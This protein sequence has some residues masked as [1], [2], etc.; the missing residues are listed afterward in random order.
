MSSGVERELIHE[1]PE[2]N[3]YEE[4]VEKLDLAPGNKK[5]GEKSYRWYAETLHGRREVELFQKADQ[6]S[7]LMSEELTRLSYKEG[8]KTYTFTIPTKYLKRVPSAK[9]WRR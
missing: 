8:K 7:S 5:K 6:G 3:I 9:L 1:E 4:A 2:K